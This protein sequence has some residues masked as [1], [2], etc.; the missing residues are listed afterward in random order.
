MTPYGWNPSYGKQKHFYHTKTM[1]RLLMTCWWQ[2]VRPPA[3][4]CVETT[5]TASMVIIILI[6]MTLS[7]GRNFRVT[8]PLCGEFTGQRWIPLTEA[9]D[10][11]LLIFPLTC[12][13]INGWVNNRGAGD[14]L[15]ILDCAHRTCLL[16]IFSYICAS[17]TQKPPR[18]LIIIFIR[19]NVMVL[20]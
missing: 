15:I 12:T 16:Y 2:G 18:S 11:G 9:R 14:A 4:I 17:D 6:M 1:T 20:Y 7:N 5:K 10:A 8:G 3:V 19:Y 13:W